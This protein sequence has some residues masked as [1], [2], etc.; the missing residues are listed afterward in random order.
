V[1]VPSTPSYHLNKTISPSIKRKS[2]I[3]HFK[4]QF[5]NLQL[6][7]EMNEPTRGFCD[8][9]SILVI[10]VTRADLEGYFFRRAIRRSWLKAEVGFYDEAI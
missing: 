9:K 4:I 7:Y 5:K 10:I 1:I 8:G 6:D 2:K 3:G